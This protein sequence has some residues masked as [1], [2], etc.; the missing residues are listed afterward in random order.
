MEVEGE[1]VGERALAQVMVPNLPYGAA[2][3]GVHAGGGLIEEDSARAPHERDGEAELPLLPSR[4]GAGRCVRSLGKR[5][6]RQ[7]AVGL[8][9]ELGALHA[10]KGTIEMEVLYGGEA[11]VYHIH[12][13]NGS[14]VW[15]RGNE[16]QGKRSG[17][18]TDGR[19]GRED[20]RRRGGEQSGGAEE[21]ESVGEQTRRTEQRSR[22]ADLRRTE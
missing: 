17:G 18:N 5:N 2:G 4:E 21:G 6:R 20:G 3:V 22:G 8:L 10:S 15:W 14:E 11:L 19:T 12:L 7:H 16:R 1:W 9:A 13:W